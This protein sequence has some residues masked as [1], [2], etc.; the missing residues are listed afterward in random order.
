[1]G[2]KKE[3]VSDLL[4]EVAPYYNLKPTSGWSIN[5][6]N[7]QKVKLIVDIIIN[8]TTFVEM[9]EKVGIS[10][11]TLRDDLYSKLIPELKRESNLNYNSLK[12]KIKH[13]VTS[14]GK[15]KRIFVFP[16]NINL[17]I[18]IST[19]FEKEYKIG[20]TKIIWYS[21]SSFIRSKFNCKKINDEISNYYPKFSVSS[22]VVVET[23]GHESQFCADMAHDFFKLFC[24]VV[25]SSLLMNRTQSRWS[26][27]QIR[28]ISEITGSP[29]FFEYS[30]RKKYIGRWIS[31]DYI[32]SK[33]KRLDQNHI[34]KF[35]NLIS[36][37][38]KF[39][40]RYDIHFY[41]K[42]YL[43]LYQ[44]A[45]S[46][47][48][49]VTS[50]LKFWSILELL[51]FLPNNK[52]NYNLLINRVLSIYTQ[53]N[54]LINRKLEFLRERRNKLV[55]KQAGTITEDN[56]NYL[57]GVGEQLFQV[58]I[59]LTKGYNSRNRIIFLLD[60]GQKSK[61]QIKREIEYLKLLHK[62]TKR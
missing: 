30:N 3:E 21:K 25:N 12:H 46:S 61:K 6:I 62:E 60:N 53:N 8:G 32:F 37:L 5:G 7:N 56:L 59:D 24:G 27:N 55:H 9:Y 11:H 17:P 58:C 43:I 34:E 28:T 29:Y 26:V 51:T 23:I 4:N 20:D 2:L 38:V 50:F 36:I 47:P 39:N 13:I 18:S 19:N 10:E 41:F 14:S 15:S 33:S 54:E 16:T 48:D 44:E 35:S 31:D 1:M 42:K 45:I 40:K 57:R 49:K 22:Y 52:A